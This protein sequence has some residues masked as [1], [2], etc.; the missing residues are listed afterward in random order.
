MLTCHDAGLVGCGFYLETLEVSG[1]L[2]D[3]IL[4][5]PNPEANP[6]S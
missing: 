3:F 6:K 1:E 4:L 2:A 5:V